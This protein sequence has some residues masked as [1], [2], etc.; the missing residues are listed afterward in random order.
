MTSLMFLCINMRNETTEAEIKKFL[1]LFYT[2]NSDKNQNVSLYCYPTK[3][4]HVTLCDRNINSLVFV[5]H[6]RTGFL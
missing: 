2:R 3:Q 4:V 5:L 1:S 6:Y